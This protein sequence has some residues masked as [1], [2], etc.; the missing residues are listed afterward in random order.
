[1][2]HLLHF[3]T[4]VFALCMLRSTSAVSTHLIKRTVNATEIAQYR[5]GILIKDGR[6]TTCELALF[7]NRSA[8]VAANCLDYQDSSTLK[9]S[10][11]YE[12]YIQGSM[13]SD[14]ERHKIEEIT[15]H[16]LYNSTLLTNN[17]AVVSFNSRK[18]QSLFNYIAADR[19]EWKDLYYV[20]RTMKDVAAMSWYDPIVRSDTHAYTE[21]SQL[22]QV[23]K[24]NTNSFICSNTT[25]VSVYNSLCSIPFSSIYGVVGSQ[26]AIAAL[27]SHTAVI[28]DS[29]CGSSVQFSYYTV[30]SNYVPWGEKVLNS[31]IYVLTV[32]RAFQKSTNVSFAMNPVSSDSPRF[33]TRLGGD[34]YAK[35]GT[36][37]KPSA[38]SDDQNS[39]LS[40]SAGT[41]SNTPGN[42]ASSSTSSGLTRGQIITIAVAVPI[43]AILAVV[44]LFFLYRWWSK[45]KIAGYW[46]SSRNSVPAH[47]I[48]R[49]LY[50]GEDR[51]NSGSRSPTLRRVI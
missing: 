15:V 17:I 32:N 22:S 44:G 6:Q 41:P 36:L 1:M 39:S 9:N 42:P 8:F 51:S 38:T 26:M 3:I 34:I 30:L 50:Q 29:M 33:V 14:S 49:E 23:F 31:P 7:D 10:T 27:Y 16:P 2:S 24:S 47:G 40:T 19:K 35:Q 48:S 46:N 43:A 25:T 5:G 11:V 13:G 28:G 21:C 18:Q 4:L 37:Q 20:R 45:R 12:V